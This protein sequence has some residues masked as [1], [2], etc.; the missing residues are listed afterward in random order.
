MNALE[1]AVDGLAKEKMFLLQ[2]RLGSNF[3][4][5]HS[6][7]VSDAKKRISEIDKEIERLLAFD[8]Y[9]EPRHK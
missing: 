4:K 8:F 2:E 5:Y 6:D 7:L 9:P 3:Y 1:I